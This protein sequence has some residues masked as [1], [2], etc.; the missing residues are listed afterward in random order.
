MSPT[1]DRYDELYGRL[2][3]A[4][5]AEP[6][7]LLVAHR[8]LL[9]PARPVLDVGAGQGRHTLLL[10]AE[11]FDVEAVDP[12][13][14]AIETLRARASE[15]G[16]HVRATVAG[17]DTFAADAAGYG[18]VLLFGLFPDLRRDAIDDLVGHIDRWT[19]PGS[20]VF[21]TAF[22]TDD[23]SHPLYAAGERVGL[24][25]YVHS[26]H[27]QRTFLEPGELPSVFP[28]F[29][30]EHLAEEI[31]PEHRHGDGPLERHARAAAVLRRA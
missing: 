1:T 27:G 26:R 19:A 21:V 20:L 15:R 14:V 16:L 17:F 2:D 22:T 5:G 6:D 9:D 3:E 11:G 23:A 31:G 13:P 7:P 24:H 8:H 18:A 25:S 28:G 29:V 4:F 12:S 10:A 30:A